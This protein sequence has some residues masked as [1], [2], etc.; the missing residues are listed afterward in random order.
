MHFSYG[1]GRGLGDEN[2]VD[3]DKEG[4]EIVAL[5]VQDDESEVRS[6]EKQAI[7][8]K[9]HNSVVKNLGWIAHIKSQPPW[10]QLDWYERRP[11]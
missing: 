3:S 6:Q 10:T 4:N 11:E 2:P 5:R 8:K 1:G 9:M 7:F